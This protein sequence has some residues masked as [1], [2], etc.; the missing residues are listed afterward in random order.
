MHLLKVFVDF[1]DI[2][3]RVQSILQ[4]FCTFDLQKTT[5]K[6]V[7]RQTEDS[8]TVFLSMTGYTSRA[9]CRS[10]KCSDYQE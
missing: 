10:A 2:L 5:G 8:S 9:C 4:A 1:E 3:I 7:I 6:W